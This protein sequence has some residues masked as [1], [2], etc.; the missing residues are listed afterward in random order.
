[1][2]KR[3]L[4]TFL[5]LLIILTS[6]PIS[7]ASAATDFYFAGSD[8]SSNA[9]IASTL[10]YVVSV[11][12]PG[13]HYFVSDGGNNINGNKNKPCT[14]YGNGCGYFGL[15]W[16]CL[17]YVRWVQY[18]LFGFH[19]MSSTAFVE[20]SGYNNAT[21]STC[22]N[23]F[24]T[25]KN[26]L[27]PGAHIRFANHSILYLSQDSNGVT[28]L[29]CNWGRT[30]MVKYATLSWSDFA[31]LFGSVYYCNYYKD[32][33][34]AFPED[35][36]AVSKAPGLYKTVVPNSTLN[37]RSEPTTSSIVLA[38]IPD[39][40]QLTV[41]KIQGSWGY[42]TYNN[43]SG[44][45]SLDFAELVEPFTYTVEYNT[46]ADIS[47]VEINFGS[48][49]SVS[50]NTESNDGYSFA[51]WTVQRKSDGKWF[52]DNGWFTEDEIEKNSY[53]K[54][55]FTSGTRIL[56]KET[57]I[58]DVTKE[59]TFT[60]EPQWTKIELGKYKVNTPNSALNLRSEP[61]TS[62]IVLNSIPDKTEL[63]IT[64]I[65]GKWGKTSYLGAAGWIH[66][67]YVEFIAPFEKTITSLTVN[68]MPIK[69]EYFIGESLDVTGLTLTAKYNDGTSE[70]ITDFSYSEITFTTTGATRVTVSY[71]TFNVSFNVNVSVKIVTE[72][73]KLFKSIT[74]ESV[75]GNIIFTVTTPATTIN[76]V[77]VALADDKSGY[78]KYSSTYEI[79]T[80]GDYVWT[81]KIPAPSETTQYA[82]DARSTISGKYLKDYHYQTITVEKQQLIK[83]VSELTSNGKTVFTV[84]TESGNYSRLRVGLS[85]SLTDNLAVTPS[86]TINEDGDFV[87]TL[88]IKAQEEGTTVYFDLRD[89]ETNK[90]IKEYYQ[91]TTAVKE[92]V[93][94]SVKATKSDNKLVFTVVTASGNYSRLRVGPQKS[95]ANNLAI[96][97]KYTVNESGD[98]VWTISTDIPAENTTLYFDLR[99]AET[100]KYIENHYVYNVDVSQFSENIIKSVQAT[101]NGDKTV[102]TVVTEAGNYSRLRV[103]TQK[104]TAN[105]LAVSTKYTV[106]ESGNYVWAISITTPADATTLYFDLRD[107]ETSKYINQH[108]IYNFNA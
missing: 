84:V 19:E 53:S 22:K 68:T 29:H 21:A 57:W 69:T 49:I 86:Y 48:T 20:L 55:L 35:G 34:S 41:T 106:N 90:Y 65:N 36:S 45:I 75:D 64:E 85:E 39:N 81:I 63:D 66:L 14:A 96:S 73:E 91:Y 16:Q 8:H 67:D 2:N 76:R 52:T 58:D 47:P 92:A 4:S 50:D 33:Y 31:S 98:F 26:K 25:N 88:S 61:T 42:T 78:I 77:K 24:Q 51:G 56:F 102:F 79:D 5:I 3:L 71:D 37:F 40:T 44:W 74:S 94:K 72:Y 103:G 70:T 7:N 12:V 107:A 105:N 101:Q 83:S 99:D 10:D 23:W 82:F 87:W 27:H 104:T 18:Q 62:S 9:S 13:Q 30:C 11:Y 43:I 46:S 54:T 100:N 59:E 80:N 38:S 108:Y 89:A 28:F 60:F 15:A 1:M 17:G 97:T 95:T 6:L 32:Y 93:I